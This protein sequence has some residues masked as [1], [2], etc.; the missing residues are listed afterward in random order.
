MF[1]SKS[2]P[3][4]LTIIW[5][6]V[7]SLLFH[8]IHCWF[9][10]P[11]SSIFDSIF[12][13]FQYFFQFFKAFF[14]I[15]F[16]TIVPKTHNCRSRTQILANKLAHQTHNWTRHFCP[17]ILFY[18]EKKMQCLWKNNANHKFTS[19]YIPFNFKESLNI[20]NLCHLFTSKMI[21][22]NNSKWKC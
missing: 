20:S 1:F 3:S 4:L 15:F 21:Y 5:S 2:L 12:R 11:F 6:N 22:V 10:K 14:R 19:Q 9:S 8:S 17:Y 7:F 16:C 18:L 13:D